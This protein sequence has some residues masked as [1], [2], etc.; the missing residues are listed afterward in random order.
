MRRKINFGVITTLVAIALVIIFLVGFAVFHTTESEN[1]KRDMDFAMKTKYNM[2]IMS[3]EVSSV[4]FT[5]MKKASLSY[6]VTVKEVVDNTKY[7]YSTYYYDFEVEKKNGTWE[8]VFS[9]IDIGR[10]SLYDGK[11]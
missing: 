2:S 3:S 9:N 5:S 4:E 8:I 10:P 11:I 7:E 6:I 1:I